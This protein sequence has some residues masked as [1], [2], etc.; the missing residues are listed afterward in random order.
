[1]N[2]LP[3][4]LRGSLEGTTDRSASSAGPLPTWYPPLAQPFLKQCSLAHPLFSSRLPEVHGT[5]FAGM[6]DKNNF[7]HF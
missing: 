7:A 2:V 6:A 1:M 3:Q 4:N 5:L